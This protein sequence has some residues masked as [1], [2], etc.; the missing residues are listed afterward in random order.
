MAKRARRVAPSKKVATKRAKRDT[1]KKAADMSKKA[2]KKESKGGGRKRPAF[3]L[4]LDH[5]R[6]P[7]RGTGPRISKD[8]E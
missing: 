5:G 1:A 4:G 2:I 7:T 6:L 3:N 8:D